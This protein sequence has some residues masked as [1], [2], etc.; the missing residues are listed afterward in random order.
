MDIFLSQLALIMLVTWLATPSKSFGTGISVVASNIG[1]KTHHLDATLSI[2][3]FFCSQ[4][5]WA[6]FTEDVMPKPYSLDLRSQIL[7]DYDGGVPIEDLTQHYAVSRSWL[8]SLIKQRDETGSIAPKEY[9][10]G[11]KSKLSPYEDVVRK[12]VAEHP[13]A[14]LID[15]CDLLSEHTSVVPTTMSNYLHQLKITRKKKLSTQANST[16][17][18]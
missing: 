4:H 1:R 18:M 13:D 15:F 10:R 2:F 17:Q 12:V 7:K 8:Y 6:L 9:K 14:T 11:R 16:E 3:V 5:M